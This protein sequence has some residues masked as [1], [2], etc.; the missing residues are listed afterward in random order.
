MRSAGGRVVGREVVPEVDLTIALVLNSGEQR[1]R[2]QILIDFLGIADGT[3][4]HHPLF[5]AIQQNP[6]HDLALL[7]AIVECSSHESCL[8]GLFVGNSYA[9]AGCFALLVRYALAGEFYH[10]SMHSEV[11]FV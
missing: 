11:D 6:Q 9:H 1:K 5:V 3:A 10:P 7:I 8:F 2:R 4:D